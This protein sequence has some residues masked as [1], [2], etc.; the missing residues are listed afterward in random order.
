MITWCNRE[1]NRGRQINEEDEMQWKIWWKSC[2]AP[3]GHTNWT[4]QTSEDEN[5]HTVRWHIINIVDQIK[6]FYYFS[7]RLCDSNLTEKSCSA[8]AS[9]ISSNSSSLAEL[10][11]SNNNLQDSGVKLLC[12]GLK[13]LQC[14]LEALQYVSS[15]FVVI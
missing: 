15:H 14:K 7:P 1:R 2:T 10:D 9:V 4:L 5:Q 11:I 3:F 12:T 13:N 8:L 6:Y